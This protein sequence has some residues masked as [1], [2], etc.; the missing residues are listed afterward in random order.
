MPHPYY[1]FLLRAQGYAQVANAGARAGA[2]EALVARRWRQIDDE[3]IERLTIT[4][5][6][7]PVRRPA[8]RLRRGIADEVICLKLQ[9]GPDGDHD[10]LLRMLALACAAR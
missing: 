1:D 2:A 10:G 7:E 3:L 5:T 6:P 9:S 8:R 4:G